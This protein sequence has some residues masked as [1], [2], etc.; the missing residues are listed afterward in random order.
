MAR[1]RTHALRRDTDLAIGSRKTGR[2]ASLLH[3]DPAVR[4]SILAQKGYLDDGTAL[5]EWS[6]QQR[7]RRALE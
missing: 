2:P 1:F 7:V 6:P 5:S 4:M 3:G